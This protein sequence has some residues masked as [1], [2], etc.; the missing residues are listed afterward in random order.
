MIIN[1]PNKSLGMKGL[2]PLSILKKKPAVEQ[3]AEGL[4]K[5]PLKNP[6]GDLFALPQE[7][8][9]VSETKKGTARLSLQEDVQAMQSN[10][11]QAGKTGKP[12]TEVQ[13]AVQGGQSP[14]TAIYKYMKARGYS[15][16]QMDKVA[17]FLESVMKYGKVTSSRNDTLTGR[18]LIDVIADGIKEKGISDKQIDLL[19]NGDFSFN[20]YLAMVKDGQSI[21]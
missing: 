15:K 7:K 2:D 19:A 21:V 9:S 8:L 17:N 16:D 5:G 1:D 14:A 3:G 4:P 12:V 18:N 10:W 13:K 6:L 20:A 11:I